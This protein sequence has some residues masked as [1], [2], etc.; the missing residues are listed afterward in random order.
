[1]HKFSRRS[2]GLLAVL[3]AA[4]LAACSGNAVPHVPGAHVQNSSPSRTTS[5]AAASSGSL[6]HP[7][8]VKYSDSGSH[9]VTGRSGSALVQSRALLA[10]DGTTLV[11]ATTGTLDGAA[12]AGNIRHVT[13][14]ATT[15]DGVAQPT[16]A[17]NNL[18][19]GGY[20]SHT[21]AGFARNETVRVDTNITQLDP[22]TDVVTTVDTVKKRPDLAARQLTGPAKAYPNQPVT[23]TANVAELNGDVGARADCVLSVD[24]QQVDQALGIW[25]DAGQA[26]SCAFQTSFATTGTKHVSVN[27]ANVVPGDWDLLNNTA[28]T[29]IEIVDP[30][31]KL[32][33]YAG[34]YEDKEE[35]AGTET[36]SDPW[37]Q[38]NRTYDYTWEYS[39]AYI[40]GYSWDHAFTFP[41]QQFEATIAV[42]GTTKL[43]RTFT[44]LSPP[45]SY[46]Y[47]YTCQNSFAPGLSASI[48]SGGT[49]MNASVQM[50]GT[51][52]TYY[53][54]TVG[55]TCSWAGCTPYSYIDNSTW[56][57]G[58]PLG[59]DLGS[60]DQF[61]LNLTDAS[62]T[63]YKGQTANTPLQASGGY[64]SPYNDCWS[65]W[66]YGYNNEQWCENGTYTQSYKSVY[67][68]DAGN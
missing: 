65:Y 52:A 54:N 46:W 32:T 45:Y 49:Y 4:A 14:T 6:F 15:V 16:D 38:Y 61:G 58:D 64:S 44:A 56:Q 50:Y 67:A 55:Q 62:G 5:V 35:N 51:R 2:F 13:T 11:E 33:T 17:Y 36:Y 43:D 10:K 42:D 7:N 40:S 9:P 23:F 19:A 66:Y 34:A 8:S 68:Y 27:V 37:S 53:S 12:G 21:Y 48:C 1:M 24:G 22:R 39:N 3:S 31:V 63:Q 25:V 47:G 26:V 28:Q 60:S 20:W 59:F 30:I 57:D 41:A 18:S 29:T